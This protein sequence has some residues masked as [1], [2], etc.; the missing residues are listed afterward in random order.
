VREADIVIA[1]ALVPGERAPVLLTAAMVRQMKPGSVIVDVAIDQGG[2]CEVTQGGETVTVHDVVV[3]GTQNI[4]GGMPVDATWLFA[5]NVL[6]CVQHLFPAG[7]TKPV[8]DDEIAH[9]MLVTY[10]G[11]I[12]HAGTLKAMHELELVPAGV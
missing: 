9:G 2:N 3:I 1:S 4:P 6:S 8:L 10:H 7:A 11:E 5:K 12:V